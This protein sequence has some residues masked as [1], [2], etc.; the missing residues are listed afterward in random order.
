MPRAIVFALCALSMSCAIARDD[1]PASAGTL[2]YEVV[3]TLP[4][5]SQSFTQGLAF[6]EGRLLESSG[7]YGR[8][9][10]ALRDIASVTPR[11]RVDVDRKYFAEGIASDGYRIV[12]LTWRAGV[13]FVYDLSL[14]RTGEM[15][16]SGEG[17]GLAWDG[18]Q[19]L[20]SD[21]SAH[22]THRD[23]RDFSVKGDDLVVRDAGVPVTELNELEY[24]QGMIYANVWHSDRVAVID[25]QSGAVRHWIDLSALKEGFVKPERWNESEYVLNGIAFNPGNGHFYVTGKCWPVLYELRLLPPAP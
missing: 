3:A 4:H 22:I 15:A 7:L 2:R 11:R 19:Y 13:A 10:V 23:A 18:R 9:A 8:S 12:Q 24:A 5:D 21:G 1:A 25:P 14:R 6:L 20:M 16:Y 17:W